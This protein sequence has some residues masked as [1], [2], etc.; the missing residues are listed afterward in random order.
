MPVRSSLGVP[1]IRINSET[2]PY[3]LGAAACTVLLLA[4][5][6]RSGSPSSKVEQPKNDSKSDIDGTVVGEEEGLQMLSISLDLEDEQSDAVKRMVKHLVTMRDN[7]TK[8]GSVLQQFLSPEDAKQRRL[9]VSSTLPPFQ[10]QTAHLI[11]EVQGAKKRGMPLLVEGAP[12]IGKAT[13]LETYV[14]SEG[15]HRPAIYLR[16]SDALNKKHGGSATE[17]DDGEEVDDDVTLSSEISE[18]D[19]QRSLAR[20]FGYKRPA[21]LNTTDE[22][23]GED[24]MHVLMQISQAIRHIAPAFSAPTLLVID[25]IQ[26]LFHNHR[27][28]HDR[29]TGLDET[30]QWF[31]QCEAEG[32]LDVILC[33]S[34]K[35]ALAG[36]RR[37]KGYD[38]TLSYRCL[39]SVDDQEVVQYL[40]S[41][42]NNILPEHQKFTEQLAYE[43]VSNFSSNMMELS[44]YVAQYR[45]LNEFIDQ[46]E[47][48]HIVYLSK[49]LPEN[50]S[51]DILRD[52]VLS[53]IFRNGVMPVHQLERHQLSLVE[54]LLENN[55]LRWRDGRA[56]RRESLS[57]NRNSIVSSKGS[58]AVTPLPLS[59]NG[60]DDPNPDPNL[61]DEAEK[62]DEDED[63][64][65][66]R[67][68]PFALFGRAG[69]ELVWYNQHVQT[70]CERWFNQAY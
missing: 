30:F 18:N 51:E 65:E 43:F 22:D 42:V 27:L 61:E 60:W 14:A 15:A 68:N 66:L 23:D 1:R 17:E 26:L 21:D 53:M 64:A 47:S 49:H 13:A 52:L 7:A 56:R 8:K 38:W 59:E 34:E 24:I 58:F 40:I 20:A 70:V 62:E 3:L 69:A 41:S 12:G 9:S 29:Y 55:I 57:Y 44:R 39:E 28:L 10:A 37:L 50:T 6:T 4:L 48:D 2:A 33:S 54:T 36:I 45:P 16:L 19:W 5:W 25:D 63:D 46:R 32:I 35:S 31:L 67:D 11:S